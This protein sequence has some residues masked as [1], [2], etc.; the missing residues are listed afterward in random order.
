MKIE[1]KGPIINDGDQWIYDWFD[2]PA[3]SPK[4]V[5]DQL[6]L[7]IR[8][9]VKEITVPINSGGGSV[10]AA[11]EIYTDLKSFPGKVRTQIVG[12]AASAA[13]CIAMAGFAE[14]SPVGMM[15]IHNAATSARGDYN[16]MDGTSEFLQKVNKT[17][18]NAYRTKTSKSEE[19][20]LEMMNKTTWMT[21]GEAKQLGF[22]D[23]IMFENEID[24]VASAEHPA[25]VDGMIPKKVL[26]EL[27]QQLKQDPGQVVN[28]TAQKEEPKAMNLEQLK[29]DHPELVKQIQNEAIQNERKR[30]QEIDNI[31]QPGMESITNKAK[32][33]SGITA[34]DTAMEILKAQNAQRA[35]QLTNMKTDAETL[36]QIQATEAPAPNADAAVETLLNK[37]LGG[38]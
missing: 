11:S 34:A 36:N 2:I 26:D 30:I 20:I 8:N 4:K 25:L 23:S 33:E 12:M 5:K 6:D 35:N 17:I 27:R 22:I 15:M 38:M 7:A 19:E 28:S 1:I 24:V 31:S 18:T 3:T 10:Y 9:Q 37:V 13:S 21:A 29:N 16:E 14:M 32:F